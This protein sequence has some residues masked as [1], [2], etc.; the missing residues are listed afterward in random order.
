MKVGSPYAT[1]VTQ[2]RSF[3]YAVYAVEQEGSRADVDVSGE[4][5]QENVVEVVSLK[6]E[7]NIVPLE[8][9]TDVE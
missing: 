5:A 3:L 9:A 6:V 8:T 4:V 1:S 7:V 2:K